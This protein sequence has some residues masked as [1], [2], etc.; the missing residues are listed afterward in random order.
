MSLKFFMITL[1]MLFLPCFAFADDSNLS[2]E[3]E[4]QE[5]LKRAVDSA[6]ASKK[7]QAHFESLPAAEQE[8]LGE[9]FFWA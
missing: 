7:R 8:R 5:G 9:G 1:C 4:F 6:N 2:R 3:R